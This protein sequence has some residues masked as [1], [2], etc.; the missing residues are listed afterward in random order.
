MKNLVVIIILLAAA[1]GIYFFAWPMLKGEVSGTV[2]RDRVEGWLEAQKVR[3]EQTALCMW[4]AGVPTLPMEEMRV[5]TTQYD[6]FR[7]QLDIYDG[8]DSFSIESVNPPLVTVTIN[9]D[10]HVFRV[11]KGSPIAVSR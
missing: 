4:A 2:T 3:D 10:R 1:A 8:V 7:N 9:G 11:E 6:A 5:F